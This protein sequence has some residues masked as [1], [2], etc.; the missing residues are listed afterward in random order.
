[1]GLVVQFRFGFGICENIQVTKFTVDPGD[2]LLFMTDGL[3]ECRNPE[4]NELGTEGLVE[5][6]KN[7]ADQPIN[8]VVKTLENYLKS[9]CGEN[10]PQDDT[11][12]L[13]LRL[14]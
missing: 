5:V 13:A 7:C 6:F 4:G 11:T 2:T 9:Y 3:I 12:L 14:K 10:Y 1:M 8:E